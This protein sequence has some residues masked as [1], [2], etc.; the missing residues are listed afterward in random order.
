MGVVVQRNVRRARK[1]FLLLRV[2]PPILLDRYRVPDG[3]FVS[4]SLRL[5]FIPCRRRRRNCYILCPLL[6]DLLAL[7]SRVH[8]RVYT[9]VSVVHASPTPTRAH[10]VS[11]G[12]EVAKLARG[13]RYRI[14]QIMANDGRT[15]RSKT[16]ERR[17]NEIGKA[18]DDIC[19]RFASK[20]SNRNRY[21]TSAYQYLPM[22]GF[23]ARLISL[24]R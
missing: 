17:A 16:S 2:A 7:L 3:I 19:I 20:N 8:V 6:F 11:S 10:N 15:E 22:V 4:A 24:R 1:V 12:E 23:L 21:A 9:Y 13:S 14:C 5:S 18:W